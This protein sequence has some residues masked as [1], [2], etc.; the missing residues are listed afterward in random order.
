MEAM[1]RAIH[2]KVACSLTTLYV[3]VGAGHRA[4][5]IPREG[6]LHYSV[7]ME[8]RCDLFVCLRWLI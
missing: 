1:L 3:I 6:P 2:V 8:A 5:E 7:T 4:G